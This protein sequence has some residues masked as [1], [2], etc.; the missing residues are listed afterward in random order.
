MHPTSKIILYPLIE[1]GSYKATTL[2]IST[3]KIESTRKIIRYL[4]GVL[5]FEPKTT[6]APTQLIDYMQKALNGNQVD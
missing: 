6:N 1:N 2:N 3:C 4:Y 5:Y